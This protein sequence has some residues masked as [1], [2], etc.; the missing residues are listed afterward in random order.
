MKSKIFNYV[1]KFNENPLILL[2]DVYLNIIPFFFLLISLLILF[3]VISGIS[4]INLGLEDLN[5]IKILSYIVIIPTLIMFYFI[6]KFGVRKLWFFITILLMF[7][8]FI[9][10]I[11]ILHILE[12]ISSYTIGVLFSAVLFSLPLGIDSLRKLYQNQK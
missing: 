11:V 6:L 12:E 3:F 4:F 8:I 10:G 1:K 5:R 7:F 2:K 9:M